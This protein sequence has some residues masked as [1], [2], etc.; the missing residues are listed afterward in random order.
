[1]KLKE[2]R[3]IWLQERDEVVK[4]YDIDKFK[5]FYRKWQMRGIYHMPLPNDDRV[6]EISLRKMVYHMTS[7]TKQ[8]KED[9]E[10][11]LIEHGYSTDI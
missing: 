5:E 10:K 1:M 3:K 4:T 11:W 2:W 7:T 8:E 9:A 6:I